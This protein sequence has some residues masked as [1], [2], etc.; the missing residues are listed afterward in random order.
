M[1]HALSPLALFC[2]LALAGCPASTT[3]EDFDGAVVT[4]DTGI[5]VA[6]GGGARDSGTT[7]LPDG[8]VVPSDGSVTPPPGDGGVTPPPGDGGGPPPPPSDG[9]IVPPPFDGGPPPP[10]DGGPS[11]GTDAGPGSI[12]CGATTC[13]SGQICCATFTGGMVVQTCQSAT[14]TCMGGATL[15]CDGPE[16]CTGGQVCCGMR[17]PTG[18]TT[19]CVDAAMC[20]FGRLCHATT[21]CTGTDMCCPFM[22]LSVC[23]PR[24]F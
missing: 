24:C 11:P 7:T 17:S 21:D 6:D 3:L 1:R 23:A 12:V 22:G 20:T 8:G 10:V 19:A 16:D 9:G 5:V 15:T 13:S 14:A 4:P 18:G 2:A